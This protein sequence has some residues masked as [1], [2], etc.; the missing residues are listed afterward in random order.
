LIVDGA[1]CGYAIP[2]ELIE[3][4]LVKNSSLV[5]SL[6]PVLDQYSA[7]AD[8]LLPSPGHLES[9]QD[10]PTNSD[11]S[12]ASFSLSAPLL[13]KN[14][15][16]IDPLDVLR[17][18]APRIGVMSEIPTHEELLKAKVAAIH[19]SQRGVLFTYA[20]GNSVTISDVSSADDLWTALTA[21]AVWIDSESKQS[22][23]RLITLN[24]AVP[25]MQKQKE[26]TLT[27][28]ATGWR[29]G[30]SASHMSPILSKIFQETEL[31]PVDGSVSLNPVT[32]NAVGLAKGSSATLS[33]SR[34]SAN[35]TIMIDPTVR[36]GVIE[37]AIGPSLNGKETPANF[38]G[39]TLLH[40]CEVAN[41][42]TWRITPAQ[43]LKA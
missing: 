39:T 12:K 36:P 30:V 41:D 42:G 26:E 28:I 37:T 6:S 22:K 21:G 9:M 4:K 25:P 3:R 15:D 14:E 13:K 31:R 32:A 27:M 7:H 29:G 8:I 38:T 20:D 19:A 10:I 16:S 11:T 40:L 34:G 33:T 43:F 17:A 24:I 35:V 18:M 1:D 5:V 23:P 2:W